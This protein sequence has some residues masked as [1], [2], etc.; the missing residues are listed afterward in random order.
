M[1]VNLGKIDSQIRKLQEIRRLLADP[2]ATR[3]IESAFT[4]R[5]NGFRPRQGAQL[6]TLPLTHTRAVWKCIAAMPGPFS[7]STI[8]E[9]LRASGI[10][11]QNHTISGII[12]QLRRRGRVRIVERGSGR[13]P[14]LCERVPIE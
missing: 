5:Q 2:E 12:N 6:Q 10:N 8:G 4:Q 3:L 9:S 11:V 13:R 1:P 14:N 7:A